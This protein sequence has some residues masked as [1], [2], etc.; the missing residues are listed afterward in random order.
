M[1]LVAQPEQ[2]HAECLVGHYRHAPVARRHDPLCCRRAAFSRTHLRVRRVAVLVAVDALPEQIAV[3]V[4]ANHQAVPNAGAA[5][6]GAGA[7]VTDAGLAVAQR[8][9]VR[10]LATLLDPRPARDH[11]ATVTHG[12]RAPALVVDQLCV[13][14]SLIALRPQV[15]AVARCDKGHPANDPAAAAAQAHDR[16]TGRVV[17]DLQVGA[18]PVQV[19]IVDWAPFRRAAGLVDHRDARRVVL[20]E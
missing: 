13:G 2:P 1:P 11:E 14:G 10:H 18:F 4:H 9:V 19:G 17:R 16:D 6:D 20:R 3:H 12:C 8:R 7:R 15:G 5:W